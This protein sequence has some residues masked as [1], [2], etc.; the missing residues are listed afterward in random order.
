[1]SETTTQA[2]PASETRVVAFMS[3]EPKKH[4]VRYNCTESDPIVDSVYIRRAAWTKM[5]R[6]V[7][8]TIEP[9]F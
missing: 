6:G 7:K 9:I 8:V 4:S 5:P 2:P 3:N 1:M